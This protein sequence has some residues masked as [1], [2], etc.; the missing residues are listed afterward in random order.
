MDLGITGIE[1]TDWG[2][3]RPK[4]APPAA[5]H[6]EAA[7]GNLD[8]VREICEA[9]GPERRE[10]LEQAD[11]FGDTA[12]IKAC[13][14]GHADVA[15]YLLTCGANVDARNE[16]GYTA[17]ML[18]CYWEQLAV[19]ELLLAHGA[20]VTAESRN[21]RTCFDTARTPRVRALLAAAT[22]RPT[23]KEF[24]GG[25]VVRSRAPLSTISTGNQQQ[26][27][28]PASRSATHPDG[29]TWRHLTYFARVVLMHTV[30]ACCR[31]WMRRPE[32]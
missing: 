28:R 13:R 32:V 12:L 11:E 4:G 22:G 9:Q 7:H 25:P 21:G 23:D 1:Q 2:V 20:D 26:P 31:P 27:N 29:H 18:A 16:D 15:E 6:G 17:L 30:V 3:S 8:A 10:L 14:R 5:L 24:V 19:I